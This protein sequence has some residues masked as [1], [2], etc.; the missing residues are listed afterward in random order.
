L[1]ARLHGWTYIH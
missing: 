1:L